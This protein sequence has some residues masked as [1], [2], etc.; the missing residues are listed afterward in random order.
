MPRFG[1]ILVFHQLEFLMVS[2]ADLS[3]DP[4]SVHPL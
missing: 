4:A 3:E 2:A 1:A